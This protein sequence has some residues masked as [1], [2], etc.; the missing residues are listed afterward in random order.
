M[1]KVQALAAS[2][3]VGALLCAPVSAQPEWTEE[4]K[5]TFST[6]VQIPGMTLP[7]G[8]YTFRLANPEAGRNIVQIFDATGQRLITTKAV[9]A[10]QRTRPT[11]DLFL[12]LAESGDGAP[13]ALKSWFYPG[14]LTGHEFVY[15]KDEAQ[16]I[17]DRSRQ[18]VLSG[19]LDA[20]DKESWQKGSVTR[21][22]P[23]SK[24]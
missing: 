10:K 6:P 17:A 7:P 3:L 1:R 4:T 20:K 12:E 5:I 16:R 2:G 18:D 19:D 13:P 24:Q 21:L 23:G 22:K 9:I 11:G 14:K 8:T 15:S